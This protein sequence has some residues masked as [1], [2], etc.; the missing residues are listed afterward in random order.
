M[1][2]DSMV[3]CLSVDTLVQVVHGRVGLEAVDRHACLDLAL[4]SLALFQTLTESAPS[5]LGFEA[6]PPSSALL[7]QA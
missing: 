2:R 5:L 6:P 4:L 7:Q 3:L 1:V